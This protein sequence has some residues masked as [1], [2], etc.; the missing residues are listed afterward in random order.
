MSIPMFGQFKNQENQKQDRVVVLPRVKKNGDIALRWGVTNAKAWRLGNQQG[1]ELIRYTILRDN[2]TLGIPEEK[3]LGLFKAK[4]LPDWMPLVEENDNAAVMA[5]ALY[6]E[7]FEVE[8]GDKLAKLVNLAEEQ[9]QRFSWGLYAADQDYKVAKMA[10]LAYIDYQTKANEKYIYKVR[11]PNQT[12]VAE[13]GVFIGPKDYEKLPQPVDF[14]GVFLDANVMLSWNYD[15]YRTVYNNYY[16]ERSEDGKQFEK[17]H[18]TPLT[19]LNDKENSTAKQLFYIDSIPNNKT[20]Y[21]R[22]RGKNPFG[23]ISPP[24][25]VVS[26]K[27]KAILRYTPRINSKKFLDDQRVILG[28]EFLV[29]GNKDITGFDLKI[30]DKAGGKYRTVIR[31]I[32][33]EAREIQ[34]DSLLPTSYFTL[35]AKGKNGS[36]RTS[37]PVLVQPVDS[38]PPMQ[39]KGLNGEIDSLGVVTLKWEPNTDKDIL[40]Y[41][42]F[43]ANHHKEE[44]SQLTIEPHKA[45]KYYDS[46]AVDNLN[47]KVY[48]QIIAVDQ[49]YNMS[50]PSDTIRLKKPDYIP[51]TPAVFKSYAIKKD[52]VILNWIPSNSTDVLEYHVLRKMQ[53]TNDWE[54][55]QKLDKNIPSSTQLFEDT[56]AEAGNTYYYQIKVIDDAGLS[57]TTHQNLVLEIPIGALKKGVKGLGSYVDKKNNFIEVFWSPYEQEGV[58][59][60]MIYRE[61]KGEPMRLLRNVLGNTTRIVDEFV[62]P[63]NEYKY[64]FRVVFNDGDVS[65]ISELNVRF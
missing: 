32:S 33:K 9:Q 57:S 14:V 17:L 25:E 63:N 27:A 11:I 2:N 18:K 3:Y 53:G 60:I 26:S 29:E 40:G 37:F 58:A 12:V 62:K 35:T 41:R 21:Y 39:P 50:V 8:G 49:R 24:S 16:V 34:Y 10:G 36:N 23:E 30:S 56:S 64:V 45:T 47:D 65:E 5:Q 42:V 6:G 55:L 1:Y 19:N 46:L 15:I 54:I 38:I 43:R 31:D 59:E 4:P 48:Y 44:L 52:K 61:K 28:W 51:P 22:V 13:A 7:G 20:Y